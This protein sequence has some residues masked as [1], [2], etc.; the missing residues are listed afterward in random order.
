M[1]IYKLFNN[2]FKENQL[3][4][5]SFQETILY[6]KSVNYIITEIQIND[7]DYENIYRLILFSHNMKCCIY[8][9]RDISEIDN[10]LSWNFDDIIPNNILLFENNYNITTCH[11]KIYN[12]YCQHIV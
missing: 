10:I 7:N 12:N 6:L 11:I 5:L 1:S 3:N 4:I 8:I 2:I 9:L